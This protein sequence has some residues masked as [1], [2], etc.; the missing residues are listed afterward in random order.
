MA[1][2]PLLVTAAGAL[3]DG[4]QKK[5]AADYNSKIMG[6]EA[7]TSGMEAN[8]ATDTQLRKGNMALGRDTAAAVQSGGGVQGSTGA[9]LHQS[10]TNS[11]LDALNVRYAGLLRSTSF[12][13]QAGIDRSEGTDAQTGALLTGAAGIL[14]QTYGSQ[15]GTYTAGG[16]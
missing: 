1:F 15:T 14:K 10:A 2:A 7:A 9:V 13:T 8:Q 4:A 6:A 16:W 12:N 11:E 3:Y 5:N